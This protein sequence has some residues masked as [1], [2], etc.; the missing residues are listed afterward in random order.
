MAMHYTTT[1]DELGALRLPW[2]VDRATRSY[3]IRISDEPHR[4]SEALQLRV[5]SIEEESVR[6]ALR[7][8][9]T[10]NGE[11]SLNKIEAIASEAEFPAIEDSM[12][13]MIGDELSLMEGCH[14]T[15]ALY[16]VGPS[17]LVLKTRVFDEGWPAYLDP[18]LTV[19]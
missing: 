15:C 11:F 7:K 6:R 4:I 10:S 5:R 9:V 3:E 18:R 14:R 16:V 17:T 12:A 19:D 8:Q 2:C 13:F 1:R